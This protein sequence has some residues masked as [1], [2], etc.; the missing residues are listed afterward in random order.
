MNKN[1]KALLTVYSLDTMKPKELAELKV[2]LRKIATQIDK[3]QYAKVA[4]FRLMNK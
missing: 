3:E 1:Y 2:W 4:R